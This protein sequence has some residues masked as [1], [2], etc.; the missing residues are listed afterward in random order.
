MNV[1]ELKKALENVPDETVVALD[2]GGYNAIEA[3]ECEYD[4][5]REILYIS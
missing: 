1:K 2:F 3:Q 4:E 5:Y